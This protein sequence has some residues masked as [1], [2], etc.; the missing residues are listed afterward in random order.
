MI[1]CFQKQNPQ[2]RS[3]IKSKLHDQ[4]SPNAGTEEEAKRG[5]RQVTTM[6]E[7]SEREST[8]Y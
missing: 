4:S 7:K 1:K 8:F 3:K 5:G 6:R 2:S